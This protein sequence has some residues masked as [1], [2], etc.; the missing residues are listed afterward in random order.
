MNEEEME[1]EEDAKHPFL[2]SLI[3]SLFALPIFYTAAIYVPF[4][5]NYRWQFAFVI[6]LIYVIVQYLIYKP[7]SNNAMEDLT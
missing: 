5:M 2:V 3:S 1:V 4:V 7:K 6:Y